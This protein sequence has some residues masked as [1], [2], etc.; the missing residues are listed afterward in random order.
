MYCLC[1][2]V[3]C[4]RE[5][6]QSQLIYHIVI[7]QEIRFPQY[8]NET[9]SVHFDTRC[10]RVVPRAKSQLPYGTEQQTVFFISDCGV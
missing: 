3:Y 2:N 8:T 7:F 4:H 9:V 6:T 5:T 1:V 10:T